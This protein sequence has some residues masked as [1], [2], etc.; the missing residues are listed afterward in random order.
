M[1][2]LSVELRK[3]QLY[4]LQ[5]RMIYHQNKTCPGYDT[6]L[7][8]VI[9]FNFRIP[10]GYVVNS[11]LQLLPGPLCPGVVVPVRVPFMDQINPF[12]NY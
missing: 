2:T 10:V 1:I 8:L 3:R 7:H 5:K 11:L 9:R 6:K 4:P 12:E